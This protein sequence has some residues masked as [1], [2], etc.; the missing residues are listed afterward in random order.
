MAQLDALLEANREYAQHFT[1]GDL[2]GPPARRLAVLTCMDARLDPQAFLGLAL[3]D[4]H[5]IRNAGGRASDDAIRSLVISSEL[6]GT[7]EFLVIHHTA[8]GMQS[9]TN[10]DLRHRLRERYGADASGVDFLPFG[11][12]AQSVRDDVRRILASPLFAPESVISGW[13]YDVRSGRL[14]QVVAPTPKATATA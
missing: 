1:Q 6:L 8:C 4:A 2:P 9:F 10:D 13:I 7:R 12:L 11:D 5:V 14:E 3:G